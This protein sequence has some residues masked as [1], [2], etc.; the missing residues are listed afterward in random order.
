MLQIGQKII[1]NS[2]SCLLLPVERN[3]DH[4]SNMTNNDT[5][6]VFIDAMLFLLIH[7][8]TSVR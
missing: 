2:E 8:S 4:I 6:F 1:Y 5:M 3:V 7:T